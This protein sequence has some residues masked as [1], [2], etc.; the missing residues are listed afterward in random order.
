MPL[1][2]IESHGKTFFIHP[3]NWNT[4]QKMTDGTMPITSRMP[5]HACSA[6]P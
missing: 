2:Q 3:D 5:A 4:P 6:T 1:A